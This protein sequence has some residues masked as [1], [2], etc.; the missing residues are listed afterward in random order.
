MSLLAVSTR[1]ALATAA[2]VLSACAVLP[3]GV[4]RTQ[5][6]AIAV[7][8]ATALGAMAIAAAP[9]RAL[10]GFRLLS[11]PDFA[12]NARTELLTRAQQSL[13]VQYYEI[14]D[15]ASGRHF[16]RLLRDAAERGVR[17]RLLVD[18]LYTAGEDSLLLGLAAQPRVEV[19]L[20]N[21]FPAGRDHTSSKFLASLFDVGR[22]N[23]RMH[24]KMMIADSAFAVV[25]G[26]NIADD[27][28]LQSVWT[29]FLDLDALV[30]GALVPRLS[31]IFDRYWNG[32]PAY[33]IEAIAAS[34][35]SPA[36]RRQ[37][38]NERV[39]QGG[40]L[41]AA[42]LPSK[43]MLGHAPLGDDMQKGT[44][45]LIWASAEVIADA[46][47][48]VLGGH[49]NGVRQQFVERVREAT[50]EVVAT[51]PYLIPGREGMKTIR[52]LRE[53]DVR[54]AMLTNSLAATDEPLAFAGYLRYRTPMLRLGVDI[55]EVTPSRVAQSRRFRLFG[56]SSGRLHAKAVVID[57]RT[58][59]LGSMNMD[60]RSRTHNAEMGLFIDS[61]ELARQILT[62]I[63]FAKRDAAYQ[64][65]LTA[66]GATAWS[67][68]DPQDDHPSTFSEEPETSLW[69]RL[70]FRL[71][72]HLVPEGLL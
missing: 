34:D 65:R 41:P 35:L 52:S 13:D 10:S 2:M 55:H 19:R 15:D 48:K 46:P 63:E 27:Y 45:D 44:L 14:R 72:Q 49:A 31:Q 22:V 59:F 21:P 64:V 28:F 32:A 47:E 38:F 16:L 62:L 9:D 17:V 60:P 67:H 11:A 30:T 43:D 37:F 26:R 71:L 23:R 24:N 6:H 8:P 58:V 70:L 56:S 18:D 5:S 33:P 51:T 42:A 3:H 20:F 29:N 39:S 7:T 1:L 61:P 53:R 12:F 69:R 36:E 40:V 54:I 68:A 4:E 25:G 57:Q 50:A 66:D